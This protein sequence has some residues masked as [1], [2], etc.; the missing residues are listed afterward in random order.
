M[1]RVEHTGNEW[2]LIERFLSAGRFGPYFERPRQQFEGVVRR[3]HSGTPW[4]DMPSEFGAWQAVCN[5]FTQWR[6]VDVFQALMDGMIIE[7]A[8]RGQADLS[9]VSVDSTVA[10]RAVVWTV[11][12]TRARGRRARACPADRYLPEGRR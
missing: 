9:L 3:F 10:D 11:G 1:S 12:R 6:D 4:R 7:A 8:R 2:E 5:R